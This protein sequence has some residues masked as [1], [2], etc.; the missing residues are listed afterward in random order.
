[1]SD[2]DLAAYLAIQSPRALLSLQLAAIAELRRR[3]VIRTKNA[4]GDYGE[5][6]A[7]LSLGLTLTNNSNAGH[8]AEGP[9]GHRYQV[10]ARHVTRANPS[11]Q[12]GSFKNLPNRKFDTAIGVLF[13]EDFSIFRAALIPY[14]RVVAI[15]TPHGEGYWRCYLRPQVLDLPDV[16][17]VTNE[18]RHAAEQVE[19]AMG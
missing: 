10:K 12:L 9:D 7:K 18:F 4:V 13:N 11:L 6:L 2:R 8:D 14:E 15:S 5:L 17:D 3:G 16:R 19:A 1:M